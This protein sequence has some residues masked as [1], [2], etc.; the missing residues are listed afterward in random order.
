[1]RPDALIVPQKHARNTRNVNLLIFESKFAKI[2]INIMSVLTD[3]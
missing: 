1:M 3:P 2:E